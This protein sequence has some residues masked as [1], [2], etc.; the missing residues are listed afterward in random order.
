MNILRTD[1][2]WGSILNAVEEEGVKERVF[3]NFPFSFQG[4]KD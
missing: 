2:G 1:T 4:K 3:Y